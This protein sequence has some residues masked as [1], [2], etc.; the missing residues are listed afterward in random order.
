MSGNIPCRVGTRFGSRDP[1][2]SREIDASVTNC[3]NGL[4]TNFDLRAR[5][6]EP[7][8]RPCDSLV[9]PTIQSSIPALADLPERQVQNTLARD[10]SKEIESLPNLQPLRNGDSVIASRGSYYMGGGNNGDGVNS[11]Q[12]AQMDQM[13]KEDEP[14]AGEPED[15]D[16]DSNE[17]FVWFSDEFAE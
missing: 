8:Q 1:R 5:N 4:L 2:V 10:C 6:V 16:D 7:M 17:I 15:D 12:S 14:V 9:I 3:V 11:E 13:L